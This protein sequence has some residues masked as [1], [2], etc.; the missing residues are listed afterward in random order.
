MS[1]ISPLQALFLA[2]LLLVV[3]YQMGFFRDPL[4]TVTWAL[5]V[6]VGITVHEANHAWVAVRLGDPTP[7][8]MG[9]VSLN[10]LRHLDPL[11][12]LMLIVARFGWGKPVLFN[13]NNLRINP[14]LGSALVSAA[15]PAANIITAFII[16]SLLSFTYA[17]GPVWIGVLEA[18]VL[19]NIILAVFNL[20]PI[21]PLDGF[22]V[23]SG[24]APRPIAVALAPLHNYGPFILL[25]L[26]ILPQMGGPNLLGQVMTPLIRTLATL[27]L[28]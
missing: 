1:R 21:P 9:R 26:I 20:L 18:I 16:A 15:G 3:L 8:L 24:L 10:P 27:V 13:P 4:E 22:G 17:L 6:V 28:S 14:A 23:V 11:G 25:A 12:T 7:R 2:G 19:V 5:A